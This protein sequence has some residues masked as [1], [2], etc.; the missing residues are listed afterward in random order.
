[1]EGAH[2]LRAQW[3]R[4]RQTPDQTGPVNIFKFINK[5][6]ELL[7]ALSGGIS[8]PTPDEIMEQFYDSLLKDRYRDVLISSLY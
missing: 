5:F 4:L 7:S 6:D 3:Q 2:E 1:M 8:A